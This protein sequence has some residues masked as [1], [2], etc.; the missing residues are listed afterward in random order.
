MVFFLTKTRLKSRMQ[1]VNITELCTVRKQVGQK[2]K[3]GEAILR[4]ELIYFLNS[5]SS[6]LPSP[7]SEAVHFETSP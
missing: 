6:S 5:C 4:L 3:A 1:L 7:S 2:W